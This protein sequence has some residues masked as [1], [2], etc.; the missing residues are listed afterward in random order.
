[1]DNLSSMLSEKDH[2]LRGKN[3]L[4][5]SL[6]AENKLLRGSIKILEKRRRGTLVEG[7]FNELED[8]LLERIEKE[9]IN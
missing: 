6:K 1:M 9:R 8:A 4:I 2:L 7:D 3:E 5:K